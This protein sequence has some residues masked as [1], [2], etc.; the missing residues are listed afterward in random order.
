MSKNNALVYTTYYRWSWTLFV[1][2]VSILDWCKQSRIEKGGYVQ[3]TL[4]QS[5]WYYVINVIL[6]HISTKYW[7]NRNVHVT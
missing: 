7:R 3:K 1:H 4:A 6:F 2:E 5:Y